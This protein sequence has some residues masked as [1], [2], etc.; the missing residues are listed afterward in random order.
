VDCLPAKEL[1]HY[2]VSHGV[3]TPMDN[4]EITNPNI[5]S[6]KAVELLLSIVQKSL[7]KGNVVP[8][9]KVVHVMQIHGNDAIVNL[10]NEIQIHLSKSDSTDGEILFVNNL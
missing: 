7:Q 9:E 4:E 3:I 8:F 5:S 6:N 10:A 2:L 1:S